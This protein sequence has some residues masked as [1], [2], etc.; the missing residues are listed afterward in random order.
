MSTLASQLGGQAVV[1]AKA[2]AAGAADEVILGPLDVQ[3]YDRFTIYVTNTLAANP[4]SS[5]RLQTAPTNLGPWINVDTGIAG[6]DCPADS[7]E[8][9]S[10]SD[11]SYKYI[12]VVGSSVLGTTINLY[13]SIGGLS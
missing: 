6:G 8:S 10:Y 11:L 2:L 12:R 13:L 3:M 7:T 4:V 1:L 5:L 9:E